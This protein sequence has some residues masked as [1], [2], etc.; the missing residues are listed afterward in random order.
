[1]EGNYTSLITFYLVMCLDYYS[2]KH[3][4]MIQEVKIEKEKKNRN[5]LFCF[6]KQEEKNYIN[7]CTNIEI[8]MHTFIFISTED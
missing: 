2:Q 1:M 3:Q 6:K 8:Q 7:L 4:I 5:K